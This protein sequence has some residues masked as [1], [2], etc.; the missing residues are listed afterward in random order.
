MEFELPQTSSLRKLMPTVQYIVQSYFNPFLSSPSGGWRL[1]DEIGLG[2]AD[3][4]SAKVR[5]TKSGT[6]SAAV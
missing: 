2:R 4:W 5:N 3:N 6:D 1:K